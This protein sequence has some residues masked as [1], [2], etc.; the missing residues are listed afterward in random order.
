MRRN[1]V[2]L[3][4]FRCF[5]IELRAAV[6]VGEGEGGRRDAEI[7]RLICRTFTAPVASSNQRAT[8]SVRRFFRNANVVYY[9]I[10]TFESFTSKRKVKVMSYNFAEYVVG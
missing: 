5:A 7:C 6:A 10:Y 9:G 3:I 2:C 8:I 1:A 4:S